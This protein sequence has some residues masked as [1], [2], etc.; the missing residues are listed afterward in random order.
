[1][2]YRCSTLAVCCTACAG[3][4]FQGVF[5]LSQEC[6]SWCGSPGSLRLGAPCG[7]EGHGI[8]QFVWQ[9]C[10]D[11]CQFKDSAA[12]LAAVVVGELAYCQHL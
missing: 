11:L 12:Q 2:V 7:E 9:D 10:V 4:G 3:L 1:M 8:V 6:G 5:V